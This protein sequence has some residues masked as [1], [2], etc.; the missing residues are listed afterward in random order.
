MSKKKDDAIEKMELFSDSGFNPLGIQISKEIGEKILK[1]AIEKHRNV[2][3]QKILETVETEIRLRDE[4]IQAMEA[5]RRQIVYYTRVLE[6]INAG[7][8]KLGLYGRF[9]FE[10]Q[11]LRIGH[12][13]P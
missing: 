8:F 2:E 6:A 5:N 10:D 13:N 7:K 11:D 1:N 3:T 9:E 12:Y 4:A